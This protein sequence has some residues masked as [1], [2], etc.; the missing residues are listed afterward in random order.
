MGC[1]M[2]GLK[3]T[4]SSIDMTEGPPWQKL[5]LFT[6]PLLV[7]NLFQQ[8]YGTA[9]AIMLGRFVGDYALAAVGSSM[10]I[11]FLI[12]V[13]LMGIAMGA[14]IVVSQYFGARRREELSYTIG[15]SISITA[16]MGVFMMI[17]GPL[18]TRPLLNML[19]TP[20]V[21]LDESVLYMNI[22]LWGILGMAY[23][24]VLSGILRSLGDAFSPL[25]YLVIACLLNIALNF[26]FI[27]ILG[28][29]VPSVA[30]GTVLAQGFS[31]IL[32][33]RRLLKM[34]DTFDMGWKYLLPKKQYCMQVLKL[35]VP[36]GAAQAVIA[37]A[38]MVVQP[39]VNNF[40][41]MVIATNVIVMQ[42]D[43]FVMMPVFSFGNAITVY[44]GQNM[45]AGKVDRVSQ[46]TKQS[47]YMAVGTAAILLIGILLFG[48]F[49]AMAFTE[50]QEIID[51]SQRMIRIIAFGYIPFTIGMVLWGAVRG[52][53]DALS[54][55][56]ASVVNTVV[57]RVPTAYLFVYWM[58]IPEAIVVSMVAAWSV[59]MLLAVLI[60]RIGK[61][62]TMS[63][64]RGRRPTGP[65]SGE[66]A[67]EGHEQ[68]S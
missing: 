44:A 20:Y 62:R 41:P 53:G 8:L 57:V 56:W 29:G 18:L 31:S 38:G 15:N 60:Y 47:L 35:G 59:N 9:D 23:F 40:G 61:W 14:G 46:G 66:A 33:L 7:G 13:L 45:G 12:M 5:L 52:A 63:I 32:C 27:V 6:V 25:L 3:K 65:P 64:V 68:F 28:W 24:F 39:L 19:S 34:Q 48:R 54:P 11:F 67:D 16:I 55:M 51:L 49:I 26:T 42:I 43:R 10:P 22:L 1:F 30:A 21:I 2:Q 17:F 58:G 36:S 37:I 4:L 50:T